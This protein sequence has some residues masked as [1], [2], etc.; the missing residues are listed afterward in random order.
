MKKV[1]LFALTIVL[2]GGTS[3]AKQK[4]LKFD[5]VAKVSYKAI[6]KGKEYP[7][8]KTIMEYS[9]NSVR[10]YKDK[11][12][13]NLIPGTPIQNIYIDYINEKIVNTAKVKDG[14]SYNYTTSFKDLKNLKFTDETAKIAGFVC[15]KAT[16]SL[17]SNSIEIWY[18]QKARVK[19]SPQPALGFI[20]GLVL[21]VVRNGSSV[22]IADKVEIKKNRKAKSLLPADYG[23]TVDRTVFKQKVDDSYVNTVNVFN[24]DQICW[25]WKKENP[26]GD[27]MNETYHFSGGTV[28]LK[29]VK[30]PNLNYDHDVYAELTQYSNGDAYDRTGTIFIIPVNKKRSFLDGLKGGKKELPIWE[31]KNGKKYQ[32]V[33]ATDEYD[34][35]IELLRFFTPFGVKHFNGKR[36]LMNWE[37]AAYY[38]KDVSEYK[39]LLKDEVYVGAF[40]GNYDKGGH[41]ISLDLKYYPGSQEV[42]STTPKDPWIAPLFN[43]LNIMEMSGQNYGTMFLGDS[44][45]VEF[46]VPE[47][48]TN[49]KMIYTTTG[50]G[51]WGTGDEFVPKENRIFVNGENIFSFTPWRKDCGTYRKF[52]PASGNFWNGVSSSDLSR[53]GWCPGTITNPVIINLTDL[54]PGKHKMTVAIPLGKNQGGTSAW[55]VSGVLI[56]DQE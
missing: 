38:K 5:R 42:Y 51:G 48:V 26:K 55:S 25:G 52:N 20:D 27:V 23:T 30:L 29:K 24:D 10:I 6:Y 49:L 2:C 22:T 35:A 17:F 14:A 47:G 7:G 37:D 31:S 41:R 4:K 9:K 1:L 43:T 53:S 54:K 45:N 19:G 34:P 11:S 28:I 21:K 44:L 13:K 32:G 12:G 3:I 46:V 39:S 8:N 56:G 16:V 36:K 50:H 33:L 18:T 40:I 15:K